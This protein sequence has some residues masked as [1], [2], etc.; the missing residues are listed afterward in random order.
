MPRNSLLLIP[1]LVWLA[2]CTGVAPRPT[3]TELRLEVAAT[4]TAFAKTMADRDHAAFTSFLAEEAV[5]LGGATPLRGKQQVAE[6]WKHLYEKPAAPF[7]WQPEKIEVL[8]SGGLALSS[9][10]VHDAKGKLVGSFTSIWRREA[11]GVWRIIFDTGD[12]A[13]ECVK[14]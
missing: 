7:S 5:F 1:C 2:A 3:A 6:A 11:P 10:P 4:E 14:Q 12:E 13:C 9:G 8:E